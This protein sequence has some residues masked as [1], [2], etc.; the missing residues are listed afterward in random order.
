MQPMQTFMETAK[1]KMVMKMSLL[2]PRGS[3]TEAVARAVAE[4]AEGLLPAASRDRALAW[5]F[6][7]R[8]PAEVMSLEVSVHLARAWTWSPCHRTVIRRR[9]SFSHHV[10]TKRSM[11]VSSPMAV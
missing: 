10:A 7:M 11:A 3:E 1:A 2:M 4:V 8:R 6:Q 5:S 9:T